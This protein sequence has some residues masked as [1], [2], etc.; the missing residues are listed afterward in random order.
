MDVALRAE[1][2]SVWVIDV[3]GELDLFTGPMLKQHLDVYNHPSVNDGHPR[4]IVYSLPE[5]W[6]IDASGLRALLTAVDGQGPETITIREP[7]SQVRRL[8]ELVD[9]DSMIEQTSE[10]IEGT[11]SFA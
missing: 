6:F 11:T 1:A 3:R 8:L 10:P 9:L 7:S 2:P 5:L 4:S